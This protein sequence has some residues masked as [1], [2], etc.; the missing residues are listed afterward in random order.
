MQH[1]L[2]KLQVLNF[3]AVHRGAGAFASYSCTA[4]HCNIR[5]GSALH[6]LK[7]VLLEGRLPSGKKAAVGRL[8]NKS[9]LR[10]K[11]RDRA[12]GLTAG[13]RTRYRVTA[14]LPVRTTLSRLQI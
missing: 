8:L 6:P 5:L 3:L 13:R 1:F 11:R 10:Q 9:A 4:F 14:S 12:H 7:G 2:L